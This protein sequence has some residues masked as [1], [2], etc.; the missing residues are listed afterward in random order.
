MATPASPGERVTGRDYALAGAAGLTA[1]IVAGV[2]WALIVKVTDY[3]IGVAA[4]GIGFLAGTTVVLAA[5]RRK[6]TTLAAIAVVAALIGILLGKYLSFVFIAREQ[7]DESYGF[8]S[9]DTWNLFMD[10][11]GIVF[12]WWDVLWTG[13]AVVTAWR[14]AQPGEP[15][16]PRPEPEPEPS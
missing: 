3:E 7:L 10:N 2:I 14:A 16:E 5:R 8:F 1:A 12:G 9:G 4:W 6:S 15:D 13:L 11:K